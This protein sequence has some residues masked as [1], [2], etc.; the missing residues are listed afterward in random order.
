MNAPPSIF[1]TLFG[2]SMLSKDVQPSNAIKPISVTL[3]GMSM[4]FKEEQ[5]SNA[6]S[7]MIVVPSLTTSFP[8]FITPLKVYRILLI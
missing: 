8:P 3:F 1:V 6:E 2:M 4:L 5:P 7:A